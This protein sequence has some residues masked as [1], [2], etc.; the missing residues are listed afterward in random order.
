MPRTLSP[1]TCPLYPPSA[2]HYNSTLSIWLSVDPM[3]DKYPST[4]PY[5]YCG[6]NPVKLVD[7]N[8]REIGEYYD[9]NGK[10]LG[11]DGK[12]DYKVYFVEDSKSQ[13]QLKKDARAHQYTSSD[14]KSE[15]ST[16]AFVLQEVVAVYDRTAG[17]GNNGQYEEASAFLTD[18]SIPALSERGTGGSVDLKL[19]HGSTSIHSHPFKSYVDSNG[20][21]IIY[22]PENRSSNDEA[23]FKN[24]AV[25]V[26]VGKSQCDP[27]SI[28]CVRRSQA[29]FYN[30]FSEKPTLTLDMDVVRKIAHQSRHSFYLPK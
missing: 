20:E 24:F 4:S 1:A 21:T 23:M 22:P 28:G 2:R 17:E 11:T 25:N 14:I 8:G 15:I 19:S 26:I 16:T 3:S 7:P 27:E 10:W 6:N 12:N 5:T 13:K 18:Y 9:M 29:C 30:S